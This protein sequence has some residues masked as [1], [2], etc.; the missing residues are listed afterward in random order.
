MSLVERSALE[1]RAL[2]GRRE[3]SPVELMDACIARIEALNPA[4]N[5]I[6]ATDFERARAQADQLMRA[7]GQTVWVQDESLM[8][9]IT[10]LSGSGPAYVFRFI[11][12]LV[13]AGEDMG[14]A[15]K[16]AALLALQTIK[17]AVALLESS[18]ETPESLRAKV[19]S[20]G[21]TTAAALASLDQD[22]FMEMMAKALACARDRGAEMSRQFS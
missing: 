16:D 21:G 14:L 11:E 2:I 3:V 12:A 1:L 7:V 13:A 19:T 10:A 4:V 9:A 22:R 5:A 15:K 17:G 20:K 8:D 6:C 18:G